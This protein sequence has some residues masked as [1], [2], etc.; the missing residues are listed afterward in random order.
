MSTTE[1]PAF[2][3]KSM[4]LGTPAASP[5]A[6]LAHFARKLEV[7]TDPFDV[8]TD[9]ANGIEG[10]VLIDVRAES[11]Y[12]ERHAAGAISL[13]RRTITAETTA[14]LPKDSTLVLYCWGPACNGA[15]KAAVALARLGYRVKEMI[16]GIEYWTREG[17]PVEGSAVEAP[18]VPR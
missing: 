17:H 1:T 3:P 18:F 12:A 16:G 11:D 14:H 2:I 6:A 10:I 9:L 13:P 8:A 5:D 15:T 4:V 7:E